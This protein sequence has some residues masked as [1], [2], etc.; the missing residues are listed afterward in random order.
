[1]TTIKRLFFFASIIF[2][3]M[4]PLTFAEINISNLQVKAVVSNQYIVQYS[5]DVDAT[6]GEAKPERCVLRISFLDD[7]GFEIY[8]KFREISLSP[9]SNHFQGQGVCKPEVWRRTKEYKAH[10]LCEKRKTRRVIPPIS[11]TA[12]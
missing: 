1:M 10:I 5:W 3:F 4:V 7:T 2:L 9:G 12:S 6:F 11:Q 8:S